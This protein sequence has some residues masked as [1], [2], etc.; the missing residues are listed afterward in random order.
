MEKNTVANFRNF[1][2][3]LWIT[4]VRSEASNGKKAKKMLNLYNSYRKEFILSNKNKSDMPI[5]AR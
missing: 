5:K 2:S 4:L 3:I 1:S